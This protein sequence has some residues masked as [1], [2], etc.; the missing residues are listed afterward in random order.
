M[1]TGIRLPWLRHAAIAF[2]P[3]AIVIVVV[4]A[5][6]PFGQTSARRL[7]GLPVSDE[8]LLLA[9]ESD[10]LREVRAALAEGA[11]LQA[12]LAPGPPAL[13]HAAPWAS[14]QL[15][16]E[17]IRG[18]ANVNDVDD[19]YVTPLGRAASFG[20]YESVQVLLKAGADP[21]GNAKSEFKPLNFAAQEGH[22]AVIEL[23]LDAG[24]DVDA[25]GIGGRTA[26]MAA[27]C[28]GQMEAAKVLVARGADVTASGS[29][30]ADAAALA[31]PD[32]PQLAKFLRGHRRGSRSVEIV[33]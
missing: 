15:V 14:A 33:K 32:Y 23:L 4:I 24:A 21:N 28:N 5:A 29:D 13:F 18:G 10:D 30:G 17:L 1:A 2:A 8:R 31:E 26:L 22:C 11:S 7:A 3:V 9:I 6:S 20:R 25:R 19:F 27:A 12:P 16:A